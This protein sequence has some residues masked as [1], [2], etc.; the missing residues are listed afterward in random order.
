V[1]GNEKELNYVRHMA[2][3]GVTKDSEV[4]QFNTSIAKIME[5]LNALYK[6]DQEVEN[7]NIPYLE[8]VLADLLKLL[9]PFA[10]HFT[11]EMWE[12]L[13]Y[14]YSVFNQ[15]WPVWDESALVRDSIELA[16]Q[17]NGKVKGRIEVPSTASEKEI[18]DMVMANP[19]TKGLIAGK[20]VVRVIV[21]KGRLVNIV[22]K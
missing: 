2:I 5:L 20:Q 13:G 21:V 12:K 15:K 17:I 18:E 11:E 10:P 19:E 3:K 14:E 22:V 8:E 4:F 16:I 7:K 6:Y 1:T 9:A